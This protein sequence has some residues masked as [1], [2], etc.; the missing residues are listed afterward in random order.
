[1][2]NLFKG[3]DPHKTGTHKFPYLAALRCKEAGLTEEQAEQLID[4]EE[5]RMPRNFK[6]GEVAEAVGSAY[7][8]SGGSLRSP[9]WPMVN[10]AKQRGVILG[11]SHVTVD[12]LRSS[13]PEPLDQSPGEILQKL[14]P[15][16]PL[17]CI[18][19]EFASGT[20]TLQL[21]KFV[22]SANRWFINK[23]SFV[24]PSAMSTR[25]GKTKAGRVTA[26][27]RENTGARQHLV[28]EI[29]DPKITKDQQA[30]ILNHLAQF[31]PLVMVVDSGN[32]SIH[33]WFA[34]HGVQEDTIAEFFKLAVE[35]GADIAPWTRCQ[36]VRMPNGIRRFE[37]G[38]KPVKQSLIY[39]HPRN[40][41]RELPVKGVQQ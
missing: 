4:A 30:A 9:K 10:K 20:H 19:E 7:G 15:G 38:R 29:D 1:M 13:S 39:F 21:S 11:N 41:K 37:D 17:V 36:L 32:K 5:H 26:R 24:V 22:E 35:V 25:Q 33:G 27:S 18:S 8:N 2:N 28:V 23:A 14:F 16:D 6:P 12:A 40:R 3:I 34:C 31:A